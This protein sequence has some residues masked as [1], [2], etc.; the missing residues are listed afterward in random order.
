[1]LNVIWSKWEFEPDSETHLRWLSD[2][3][4]G[5]TIACGYAYKPVYSWA[6]G[7]QVK[8]QLVGGELYGN[9]LEEARRCI[10][11]LFAQVVERLLEKHGML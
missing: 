11:K 5:E 1:M 3:S 2:A 9:T 8:N 6:W 4:T 10:E 7:M